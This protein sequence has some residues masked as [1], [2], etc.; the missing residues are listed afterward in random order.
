MRYLLKDKAFLLRLREFT[1]QDERQRDV[2]VVRGKLFDIG[3]VLFLEDMQGTEL[4]KI[5]KQLISLVP[6]YQIFR[7][8]QMLVDVD[9]KR[10]TLFGDQF[11]VDMKDG[12][13]DM[14][15]KGDIMDRNYQIRRGGRQVARTRRKLLTLSIGDR[16]VMDIE[17]GEDDALLLAIAVIIDRISH[18]DDAG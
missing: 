6:S 2:F 8:D 16:Y 7:N 3:D 11:K 17:D 1:I 12:S 4:L 10:F 13:E 5:R 14:V 18:E 15:V 9:K